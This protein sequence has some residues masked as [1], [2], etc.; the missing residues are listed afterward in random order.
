LDGIQFSSHQAT[1]FPSDSAFSSSLSV[2][3][4]L[5]LGIALTVVSVSVSLSPPSAHRPF[6]AISLPAAMSRCP[7]A[8]QDFTELYIS[9]SLLSF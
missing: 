7:Q 3:A 6:F 5:S 1:S 4:L 9:H 8:E 2:I